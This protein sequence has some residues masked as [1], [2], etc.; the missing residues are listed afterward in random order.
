MEVKV[1]YLVALLLLVALAGC[2]AAPPPY[3]S[4]YCPTQD[5]VRA[6]SD[7]PPAPPAIQVAIIG[8]SY[9]RGT[10]MGGR[11]AR[12]WPTLAMAELSR[13]GVDIDPAVGADVGSGYVKRGGKG[14]VFADQI[15]KVV[16]PD[17]RL[18]VLFGSLNDGSVPRRELSAPVRRTLTETQ[19]A[20]PQARLL[21]IG[22]PWVAADPPSNVLGVRDVVKCQADA[23]GA[24]FVDPIA[25]GWFVD[26]PEL[27][28]ADGVH[29]TDA[30]HQYLADKIAPLISQQLQPPTV[31]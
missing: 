30:G 11:G 6:V 19:A 2:R 14:T 16:K 21:V 29:P 8:D 27:I 10:E 9:T 31:P 28:G 20:A 4:T 26:H 13:R 3:E 7:P 1:R 12:S 22:P 5:T 23:F 15:P 25:E 24:T 17:D 18:V